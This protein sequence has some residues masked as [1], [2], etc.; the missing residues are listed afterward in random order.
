MFDQRSRYRDT[1]NAE[2]VTDSG[3]VIIYRRRRILPRVEDMQMRGAVAVIPS[4]RLDHL[5]ARTLGDPLQY[6]QLCDANP[7]M[8]PAEMLEDAS[9]SIQVPQPQFTTTR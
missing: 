1:E 9:H 6:W 4:E 3:Q 5:S 7:V 2:H 8:N